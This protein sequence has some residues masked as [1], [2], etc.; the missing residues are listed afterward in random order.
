[1][2]GESGVVFPKRRVPALSSQDVSDG[3]WPMRKPRPD[4]VFGAVRPR[5]RLPAAALRPSA[6]TVVRFPRRMLRPCQAAQ[7][8]PPELRSD[9]QLPRHPAKPPDFAGPRLRR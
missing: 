5:G 7:L 1:M 9:S 6:I 4:P 8:A 3:A 2:I